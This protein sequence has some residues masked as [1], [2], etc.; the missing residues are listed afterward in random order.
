MQCVFPL[1][2]YNIFIHYQ[3]TLCIFT[4]YNVF[5]T[6]HIQYVYLLSSCSMFIHYIQY[7]FSTIDI[8]YVFSTI[9][10]QYVFSTIYTMFI[11]YIQYQ[12]AL[13]LLTIYTLFFHFPHK[14][15]FIHYQ[16]TLC[17]FTIYNMFIH[18][19][20]YTIYMHSVY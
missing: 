11:H 13:C 9:D 17:L 5:S 14:Y 18:Y 2:T 15:K 12:H 19:I 3:H 4:I 20:Q 10:I 1:F 8:Q 16:Y 7:V 6:I